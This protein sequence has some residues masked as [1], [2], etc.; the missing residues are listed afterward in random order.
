MLAG[1]PSLKFVKLLARPFGVNAP[2]PMA[3]FSFRRWLAYKLATGINGWWI[4][5]EKPFAGTTVPGGGFVGVKWN[6]PFTA[7]ASICMLVLSRNAIPAG[8]KNSAEASSAIDV[9]AP[10]IPIARAPSSFTANAE[11]SSRCVTEQV[12][13]PASAT[14][15][16]ERAILFICFLSPLL[17]LTLGIV[18]F[19]SRILR[20]REPESPPASCSPRRHRHQQ[21]LRCRERRQRSKPGR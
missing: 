18:V 6:C 8:L 4:A 1:S 9:K 5:P 19:V 10:A 15:T 2:K 3:H 12:S 14:E 13:S 20:I 11:A 7:S 21:R 17:L 16:I